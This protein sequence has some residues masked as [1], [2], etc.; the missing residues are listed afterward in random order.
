MSFDVNYSMMKRNA[1]SSFRDESIVYAFLIT[2]WQFAS[3]GVAQVRFLLPSRVM[4]NDDDLRKC[5]QSED[6]RRLVSVMWAM[7]LSRV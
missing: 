5:E 6:P 7:Y 3:V 4:A 1:R 2:S